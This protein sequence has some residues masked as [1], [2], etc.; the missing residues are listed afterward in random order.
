MLK[1]ITKWFSLNKNVVCVTL[2]LISVLLS[3]FNLFKGL[4]NL[5]LTIITL[6]ILGIGYGI[7][8]YDIRKK[9]KNED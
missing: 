3:S 7:M 5:T 4:H 8:I 1:K 9:K 2:F 6:V